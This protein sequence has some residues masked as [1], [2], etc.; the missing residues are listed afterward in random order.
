[1]PEA[2]MTGVAFALVG[3]DRCVDG[4]SRLAATWQLGVA[5]PHVAADKLSL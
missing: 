3:D 5:D 1:M 2:G 4:C